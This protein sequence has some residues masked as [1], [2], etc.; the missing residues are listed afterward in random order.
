MFTFI[1]HGSAVGEFVSL[2]RL[3]EDGLFASLRSQGC[4]AHTPY[5]ALSRCLNA[6]QIIVLCN[7]HPLS[8]DAIHTAMQ[9][10]AAQADSPERN[11]WYAHVQH[12]G[13]FCWIPPRRLNTQRSLRQ[14]QKEKRFDDETLRFKRGGRAGHLLPD[15][16]D[17]IPR[18]TPRSWKDQRRVRKA[19]MR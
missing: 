2:D 5:P 7:G 6:L 19:W 13:R 18:F 1:Q 12:Y 3:I 10:W 17:E 8:A 16:W 4:T 11:A 9:A 14:E 15:S